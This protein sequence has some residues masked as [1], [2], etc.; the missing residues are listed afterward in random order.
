MRIWRNCADPSG[1]GSIILLKGEK[2]NDS[3][4]CTMVFGRVA[5]PHHF[6]ANPN[7]G[8]HFDAN[9]DPAF[10]SKADPRIRIQIPKI[11]RIR[12][13]N[14]GFQNATTLLA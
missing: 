1:S 2:R 6:N 8:F 7:P 10:H 4:R 5:D 9:P 11:M 14:S 3:L 13:Y 12:I